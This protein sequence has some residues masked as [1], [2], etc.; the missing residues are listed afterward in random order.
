MPGSRLSFVCAFLV[1]IC[2]CSVKEDRS[3]CPGCLILDLSSVDHET[4]DSLVVDIR[5]GGECV[6]R[7]TLFSPEFVPDYVFRVPRSSL[8]VQVYSGDGGF[9]GPGGIR[10]PRGEQC[11]PVFLYTDNVSFSGELV[12]RKVEVCKEFCELRFTVNMADGPDMSIEITG[13]IA[14]FD[15]DFHPVDGDFFFKI[16]L[17]DNCC[18]R[19]PRQRDNSLSL[20]ICLGGSLMIDFPLGEHLA[21]IGFDWSVP[22][23]PDIL[24]N[25]DIVGSYA[26]VSLTLWD[27]VCSFSVTI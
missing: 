8:N 6:L 14:G 24:I 19:V 20:T 2:S 26:L 25:F 15:G 23:L 18:V 7:K 5:E 11:P 10:I 16:P 12:Q 27:N 4:I 17:G 9:L 3:A 1:L 13:K 21:E 22:N